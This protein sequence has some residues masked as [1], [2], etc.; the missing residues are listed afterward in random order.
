[1]TQTSYE[2]KTNSVEETQILAE[3]LGEILKPGDLITLEGDLG[4]GKTSFTQGLARGLDISDTVNSPT[5]TIIKEYEGRLPLYHIDVY[6]VG[7]ELQDLGYEEYFEGDGVTVVEWASM[8]EDLLPEER[9]AVE[10]VKADDN[11]RII[12]MIPYGTRF[13]KLCKELK[14]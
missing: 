1:M 10:I 4:A 5:F 12:R 14:Q 6:R 2:W 3:S 11:S 9:L 8:V 7:E 13:E